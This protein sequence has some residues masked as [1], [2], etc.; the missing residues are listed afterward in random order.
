MAV[1]KQLIVGAGGKVGDKK[2]IFSLDNNVVLKLAYNR[3][4]SKSSQR[5]Y[6]FAPS[7]IHYHQEQM[8]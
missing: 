7:I 2:T 8:A 3:S 5:Y 1:K 6:K 4:F